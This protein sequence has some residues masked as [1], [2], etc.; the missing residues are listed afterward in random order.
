MVIPTFAHLPVPLR[1]PGQKSEIRAVILDKDNCISENYALEVYGPYKDK[2]EAL[3]AAYP[4]NRLLI[5]SN[6][7]GTQDDKDDVQL[8]SPSQI[9][10]V[11]DRLFTDVMM[12]NM[13][14]AW[15]VWVRDG[16]DVKYSSAFSGFE[17]GLHDFLV[18]RGYQPPSPLS[19]S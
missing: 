12:A 17:K 1:F 2:F 13:M 9:A 3:K 19:K 7:S 11:G 8:E 14:G 4:G 16:V 6:S 10:V 18:K 15:G 5:V